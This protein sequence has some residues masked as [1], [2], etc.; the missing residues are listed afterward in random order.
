MLKKLQANLGNEKYLNG[1]NEKNQ[2]E[3]SL[4][5]FD[6]V[7]YGEKL[8]NRYEEERKQSAESEVQGKVETRFSSGVYLD[9]EMA[10]IIN[11]LREKRLK[12]IEESRAELQAKYGEISD[13]E[14]W[15]VIKAQEEMEECVNCEGLPCKK[16]TNQTFVPRID[17]NLVLAEISVV[18]CLCKYESVR[19]KQVKLAKKYGLAKIP[20]EYLGKTFE[21]YIVDADNEYAVKAAKALIDLPDKG[22]YLYGGVGTGKTL[23]AAITAQE[24]LKAGREVIFAT[25]PTISM[26]LRSTFKNNSEIN[27]TEI[28][29]KLYT[30]QTL[31][32]DDVGME[33]PTRFVCS[34]LCNI[35][36]ER[37]NARL[38]TIMTSNYPLKALEKIFNN[39]TDGERTIDG[40]RIYDRCK[41]MCVPIE[42]KGNSRR[43]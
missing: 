33:K 21:D 18:R 4:E 34:T 31:I 39:P 35:F 43:N 14:I 13:D 2:S 37:Y 28:L 23:L 5:K 8:K 3:T 36:N 1:Y 6:F 27:E 26:Q 10:S 19:R 25:V 12:K 41:Q 38:Q 20:P 15:Q 7:A 40:T 29:E 17:F 22:V 32:L 30:V 9:E 42:L 16:R 24:I 11:E